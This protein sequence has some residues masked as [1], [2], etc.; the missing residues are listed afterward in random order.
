MVES[1]LPGA[2]APGAAGRLDWGRLPRLRPRN[3]P[4]WLFAAYIASMPLYCLVRTFG[5][6]GA[7]WAATAL[8]CA[9]WFLCALAA[10]RARNGARRSIAMLLTGFATAFTFE[11]LGSRYGFL[12]G[13]Y[14][15]TDLLGFKLLGEVPVLVPTAWF[16]MLYPSWKIAEALSLRAPRAVPKKVAQVAIGA[17]AMTAWDLSLD[18]RWVADGAWIW[19][20]GGVYFGIPLSNFAGW[21]VTA[22]VIFS[23]WTL[24]DRSRASGGRESSVPHWVYVIT[25]IGESVANA[26]FW[27]GPVIGAIVFVAMGAFAVP[28]VRAYWANRRA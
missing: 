23:I 10:A 28:F 21:F 6:R 1:T 5:D 15:Y 26:L 8:T 27:Q 18:P 7:L 22:A 25:W 4:E 11:F 19:P 17:A 13:Q 20:N 2:L 16:M 3:T 9:A 12:F 24:L 14:D